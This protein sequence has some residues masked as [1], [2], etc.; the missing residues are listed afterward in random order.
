MMS[1]LG[2]RR[3]K[4][5]AT[6][7]TVLMAG[8][9]ITVSTLGILYSVRSAND[10]QMAV[11]ATTHSESGAWAAAEVIRKYLEGRAALK[12]GLTTLPATLSFALGTNAITASWLSVTAVDA[13]SYRVTT[14]IRSENAAERSTTVFQSVYTVTTGGGGSAPTTQLG[15]PLTIHNDLN[16]TGGI[17]FKGDNPRLVVEGSATLNNAS[18]TGLK[19][20]KATKDILI[21]S[22]IS[23][24]EVFANGTLTLTGSAN[25]LNGSALG[26]VTISSGGTQGVINTNSDLNIS[27]GSV[28]TGNALGNI[29]DSSGG[30]Q[31]TLTAGKDIAI[32]NGSVTESNAVGYVTITS[33]PTT[34]R[35]NSQAT[36]TCPSQYWGNYASIKAKATIGCPTSNVVAPAV[37]TINLMKPL[38]P[39]TV[40]KDHVDAYELK[41]SANYILEYVNGRMSVTVANVNGIANGTY[42]LGNYGWSGNRGWND[43]LCSAVDTN[44][45]CTLPATPDATLRTIC[46]GQST[47]NTCFSYDAASS[48][49]TVSGKNLAPGV[50]WFNGNVNLS[51]GTYYNTFLATG[52]IATSGSHKTYSENYVGYAAIC[53]NQFPINATPDFQGLY[54]TQLCDIS[55]S[56]MKSNAIGNIAYLA[57]GYVGGNFSGGQITLGASTEVFGSVIAGDLLLTG[58]SSTVHGYVTAAGQGSSTNN[59]W[60]GSTTIDLTNLPPGYDPSTIPDTSNG[61]GQGSGSGSG[62]PLAILKWARY[63]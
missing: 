52:N 40:P 20:I 7:I 59:T 42:Y 26:N 21:G 13:T 56:A 38:V 4:G 3:Q 33:W 29:T 35:V 34:T 18:I 8:L 45:N 39:F 57:G 6:I 61:S 5:M 10:R 30:S 27:N 22:G 58:G 63:L 11:H 48:T 50:F 25:T 28:A 49:W 15:S 36:V 51:N 41:D 14:N 37:V 9:A 19:T 23:V 62:T 1:S 2:P 43:F 31:G 47:S 12:D 16:L 44:R 46:Q 55:K 32:S 54:P 17:A 24:D 53:Q 60:G